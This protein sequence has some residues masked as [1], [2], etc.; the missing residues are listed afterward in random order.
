MDA[1][2]SILS[3]M[4]QTDSDTLGGRLS[5]ARE[6]AG[7]SLPQLARSIGVRRDTLAAWETDRSEPRA[8]RLVTLAGV[9]GVSP[10]WLLSGLGEPPSGNGV[11]SVYRDLLAEIERLKGIQEQA[12]AALANVKALAARIVE[13]AA[14]ERAA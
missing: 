14:E 12:A 5:R 1:N 4:N 2:V 8:N 11:P 6:A 9:L 10:V 3:D 7:F 13:D